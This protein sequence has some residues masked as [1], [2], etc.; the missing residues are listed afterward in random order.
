MSTIV[1]CPL[2]RPSRAKAPLADLA[3]ELHRQPAGLALGRDAVLG[4]S[5]RAELAGQRRRAGAVA[6]DLDLIGL[7]V[8]VL[9]VAVVDRLPA[10]LGE[11]EHASAPC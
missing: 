6:D 8:D 3:D 5:R 1:K 10:Q 11:Q 4:E 2:T 7:L 9:Q